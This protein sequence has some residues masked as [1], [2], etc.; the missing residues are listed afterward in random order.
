[1]IVRESCRQYFSKIMKQKKTIGILG[2]M[3]PAASAELYFRIIKTAQ[4]NYHAV[5]D[6][7]YPPIVIHSVPLD[8]FTEKGLVEFDLVKKQ[9]ISSVKK[10]E[11]SGADL[12]IIACNTVHYYFSEMQ[13]VVK[14]PILNLIDETVAVVA[15][16]KISKVGILASDSTIKL[17]LYE[18]KLNKKG[19]QSILPNSSQQK[20]L[21]K[22]IL[23]VMKGVN[24]GP[25]RRVLLAIIAD[26]INQGAQGI[27]IGCT[28]L[29]LVFRDVKISIPVFDSLE[30]LAQAAVRHSLK[31]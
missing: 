11:S 24:D 30:I 28:E 17:G 19:I 4:Q 20:R 21:D 18:N 6:C 15:R 22:I 5:Q 13:A 16:A 14:V 10:L 2:G 31:K 29:P 23:N 1:M 3:G 7:D 25:E 8:G 12:I 26:Y 27:V 9:L